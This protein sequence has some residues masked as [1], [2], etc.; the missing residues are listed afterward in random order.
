M[1]IRTLY[2][3]FLVCHLAI[4]PQMWMHALNICTIYIHTHTASKCRVWRPNSRT[5]KI[6]FHTLLWIAQSDSSEL[7][8][9]LHN[10][11]AKTGEWGG[12]EMV[13]ILF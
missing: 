13:F 5:C 4:F 10:N 2:N 1:S 6:L 11:K 3:L 12:C 9:L 8:L 7:N